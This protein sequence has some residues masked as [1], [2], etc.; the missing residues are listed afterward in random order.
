MP[1][2]SL[3]SLDPDTLR[4]L[5]GRSFIVR[6]ALGID[7]PCK[8]KLLA[9]TEVLFVML[10]GA[11]NRAKL[12]LPVFARW[13]YG[14]VLGG[15]VLAV[16]D[17]TLYLDESLRLGWFAGNR[18][19]DPMR[20][21]LSVVEAVRLGLG[22]AQDRVVFHGSSGGGFASIVAA[23]RVHCGRALVINPQTEILAYDVRAV[24]RFARVFA[25]EWTAQECRRRFPLRWSALDA[26]AAAERGNR[27]LRLVYAQN[28][29]D[30]EHYSHHYLPFCAAT[31]SPTAG[32]ANADG[33]MLTYTYASPEGHASE[34]PEVVRFLAA[35]GLAHLFGGGTDHHVPAVVTSGREGGNMA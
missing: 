7:L 26:I 28:M 16:C 21:L 24:E 29:D 30:A 13:N 32:G 17:P 5:D 20:A 34:P 2:Y 9:G 6:R 23:S 8:L 11:V 27:D 22:I 25:P 10:N 35:G 4:K 15:H 3:K 31:G 14:K 1:R 18:H 12:Q 19:I 33:R